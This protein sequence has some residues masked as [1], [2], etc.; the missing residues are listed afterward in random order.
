M[1][2]Q[3]SDSIVVKSRDL[4]IS[5]NSSITYCLMLGNVFNLSVPL[6]LSVKQPKTRS[7]TIV[8]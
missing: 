8:W 7:H 5:L 2:I 4:G 1:G 3:I 6:F